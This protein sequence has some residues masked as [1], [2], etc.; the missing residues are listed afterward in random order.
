M[1]LLDSIFRKSEDR[2]PLITV[3][4][5]TL[6]TCVMAAYFEGYATGAGEKPLKDVVER[7]YKYSRIREV[8]L[9]AIASAC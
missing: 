7:E 1:G 3:D 2:K 9:K 6:T 8:V 4:V 5:D